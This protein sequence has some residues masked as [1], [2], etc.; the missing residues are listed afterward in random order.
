ME[1]KHKCVR[2]IIKPILFSLFVLAALSLPEC[3]F[4]HFVE[5]GVF[6]ETYVGR[7]SFFFSAGWVLFFFALCVFVLPRKLGKVIFSV[8]TVCFSVLSLSECVYYEIFD[9]F[10]WLK[11]IGL[12]GEGLEYFDYAA[13]LIAPWMIISFVLTVVLTLAALFTWWAPNLHIKYRI[14]ILFAPVLILLGTHFSMQPEF[15]G[16]SAD[17]WDVWRKPRIVYKNF[18][19]VN[20]SIE[21]AGV[22]HFSYLNLYTALFPQGHNLSKDERYMA[23]EYFALKGEPAKNQYSGLLKGKNVVAVMM[24]S[25]DTWMINEETTPTLYKMMNNGIHFMNYNAPFF[26]SGFTFGS[27]FAFNTGFF[28]PVS[29]SNASVFSKNTFPYSLARLFKEAGYHTN[30]FHFNSPEFYNRGIMHKSFGYE[31]YHSIADFGV[32]GVE[33][34]LD[35]NLMRNDALF[36]KMTEQTPFFNFFI[37]YSAHLP[38]RGDSAKL[39]LAKEY[40]PDLIDEE[41]DEEKNNIRVLA[42]DTDEFF[43][44]LLERLEEAGLLQDT[45]I[46]AYTDHFAYGV[47]SEEKLEEWKGDT[48][49][50]CVPAF[51]YNPGLKAKKILKPMMTI[52]WA[53]TIVNL[54]DLSAEAR[55]LG[56]DALDLESDGFIYFETGAWMDNT[57]HYI[58]AEKSVWKED[59]LYIEKQIR[60][61]KKSIQI[62]DMVILGDYYKKQ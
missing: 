54:F 2:K 23:D 33:K 17:E 49:S 7:A 31:K 56:S 28:T 43:R 8:T 5:P 40:R 34:E 57:T 14:L 1:D 3:M 36:E 32:E 55:Y 58:P 27:E 19:D 50:Y 15:Y 9:Q 39:A 41:E 62:N 24:E 38:Y 35:S 25:I 53:P 59:L 51:I 52:D 4:R 12:A 30:S 13:K 48:L 37:T 26:G 60:R 46:I 44:L 47:S 6:T 29:A 45:V 61:M 10:F 20:K 42:A 21:I 22:Y 16:D 18:N 11:S